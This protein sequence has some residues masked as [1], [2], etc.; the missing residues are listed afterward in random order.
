MIWRSLFLIF[1]VALFVFLGSFEKQESGPEKVIKERVQQYEEAYNREDAKALAAMWAEDAEYIQPETGE[2]IKGRAE[3]EKQF[4]SVFK[5]TPDAKIEINVSSIEF[6]KPDQAVETGTAI[7]KSKGE[8]IDETAYKATYIK[9]GQEWLLTQVREVES[10][11]APK[12]NEHLKELNW[13]VG[14][15][16]DTDE[17]TTIDSSFAWGKYGNFMT[18][19]FTMMAEG[20]FQIEG[21]QIIAWD[22]IKKEIRSWLFDSDGGFGDGVWRK[23]DKNW[24]VE[25]SH[26]LADGRKASSINIYTPIDENSYTWQSVGREVGGELLPNI[27]PV[28]VIRKK[29]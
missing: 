13:L 28:T 9:K 18:Q 15:W 12:Q 4:I 3:I 14:D 5:E 25:M 21:R 27:N 6:P 16:V 26:T 1:S 23:K 20:K 19:K 17:D 2:L 11:E 7:V 10:A 24:V 8:L 22:P 29:G